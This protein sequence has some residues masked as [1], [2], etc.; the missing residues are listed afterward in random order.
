MW[1]W[2]APKIVF[3]EDAI[4]YLEQVNGTKAF[5]VTD[6]VMEE[7]GFVD[8]V[9]NKLTKSNI[10]TKVFNEVEPDPSVQTVRKGGEICSEYKPDLIIGLGGGSAM[11]AAKAIDFIYEQ[12]D[13]KLEDLSPFVQFKLHQKCK[14]I[15]IPTTS[16]TGAEV[17]WAVV[18]TDTK[19]RRKLL[20]AS[21]EIV[22]D[23]AIIDPIFPLKMPPSLTASTG[24]DALTHAIEGYASIWKN[25]Y[26]DAMC[27]K[28]TELVF[29]NLEKAVKNGSDIKVRENMHNAATMAGLGFGNSQA[30]IA[31]SMGH[32]IGAVFH[33]PH[34]ICVGIALPYI[35]EY[36]ISTADEPKK[37][38]A[39]ISRKSLSIVE[40]DDFEASKQLV[41]RIRKLMKDIG[42]PTSYRELE[43]SE[44]E[45]NK[46]FDL[47]IRNADQD[48]CTSTFRPM[49]S[50]E[51]FQELFKA[52]Y[53][54]TSYLNK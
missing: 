40:D 47:V 54:G 11:D 9:I 2:D 7:L 53:E 43:I 49:P 28:A 48:S 37:L 21:R 14:I 25:I 34:G 22:A 24:L 52:A 39:E 4:D 16:G 45:F 18:L 27:L 8:I 3:G 26:S 44:D 1:Y 10:D 50:K 13:M 31:H 23:I 15:Q 46:N 19:D 42:A 30:G 32:A 5:I 20:L 33:K 6:K 51:D 36:A 41:S 12:P 17:T 35:V 29:E 38:F